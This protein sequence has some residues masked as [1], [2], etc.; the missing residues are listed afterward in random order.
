MCRTENEKGGW[1]GVG[2]KN[3]QSGVEEVVLG[4]SGREE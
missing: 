2:E 1:G 3:Q 4:A